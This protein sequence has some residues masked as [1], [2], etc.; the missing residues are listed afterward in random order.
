MRT[1]MPSFLE[2]AEHMGIAFDQGD[3]DQLGHWLELMVEANKRMNLTRI[4][5]PEDA[6]HRHVLDSLSLLPMITTAHATNLIDIGSGG[7][8]PGIPLAIVCPEL[9]VGL[10]ETTGKKARFLEETVA[11]LG[12]GNVTVFNDRAE[13][14]AALDGPQ[15]AR[16]DVVTARAV[17]RLP[18]LLEL[19]IPF[20]RVGGHVLAIKGEQAPAEIEES[21]VALHR[22]HATVVDTVRT[23]TGTVVV[24]E[25]P[26]PTPKSYPRAAGEPL[27]SPLMK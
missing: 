7:G 21:K 12:L 24:V 4:L 11:A 3:L 23:T 20:A 18:V 16:W 10:V 26:R 1:P 9:E 17:G 15:R 25:K 13:R 2:S 27:R 19:T 6:W 5:H 22:L 14:L 8:A